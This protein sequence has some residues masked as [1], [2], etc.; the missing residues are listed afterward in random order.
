MCLCIGA[1]VHVCVHVCMGP[2]GCLCVYA[3][4]RCPCVHVRVE[5]LEARWSGKPINTAVCYMPTWLGGSP[6]AC[7]PPYVPRPLGVPSSEVGALLDQCSAP[8][9]GPAGETQARGALAQSQLT[10]L[11]QTNPSVCGPCAPGRCDTQ[12]AASMGQAGRRPG[13]GVAGALCQVF[14][15]RGCQVSCRST[16]VRGLP[17]GS[18]A[19]P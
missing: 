14:Q 2:C 17:R 8:S 10:I 19:G 13:R 6:R 12:G 7:P 15:P 4:C 16:R 11:F 1:H 18:S 5:G 9:Q 3:V